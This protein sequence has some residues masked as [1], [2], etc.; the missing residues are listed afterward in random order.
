MNDALLSLSLKAKRS[1]QLQARK[2]NVLHQP[3]GVFFGP[4]LRNLRAEFAGINNSC[5][6]FHLMLTRYVLESHFELIHETL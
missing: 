6:P 2:C 1:Q 4:I 3:V 5:F